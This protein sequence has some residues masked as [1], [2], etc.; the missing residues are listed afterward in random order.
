MSPLK[1]IV[2]AALVLAPNLFAAGTEPAI[3]NA[4]ALRAAS[5][6]RNADPF[7]EEAR[8]CAAILVRFTE[9]SPD[10]LVGV[11]GKTIPFLHSKDLSEQELA[12]LLGAFV[13]GNI[14]S[15]LLRGVKTD[16]PYAGELQVIETYGQMRKKR[17]RFSVP[18]IDKLIALEKAG[19]LKAQLESN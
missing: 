16:D 2:M 12:I 13:A 6:F 5:L 1:Y 18:E 15:Q 9:K 10:V 11:S 8:G 3:T 14:D 7:S 19:K 4:M 17:P